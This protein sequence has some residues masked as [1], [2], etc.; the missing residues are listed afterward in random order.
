MKPASLANKVGRCFFM[1]QRDYGTRRPKSLRALIVQANG[2][3]VCHSTVGLNVRPITREK[4]G[5]GYYIQGS[6]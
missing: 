5:L 4:D 2:K 3:P 1:Y 6:E